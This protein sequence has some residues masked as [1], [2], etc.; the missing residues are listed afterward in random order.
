MAS[1]RGWP[2]LGRTVPG[3]LSQPPRRGAA[4]QLLPD[5]TVA[6]NIKR[7]RHTRRLPTS[8]AS[9]ALRTPT[10]S[11]KFG[12][13]TRR[14]GRAG[15]SRRTAPA[16]PS[17]ASRRS[18]GPLARRGDVQSRQRERIRS[19]G[20]RSLRRGR[21]VRHRASTRRYAAPIRFSCSGGG[22]SSAARRVPWRSK[23]HKQ[24]YDK[25]N[26][27]QYRFINPGEDFTPEPASTSAP[28]GAPT[29]RCNTQRGASPMGDGGD[30]RRRLVVRRRGRRGDQRFWALSG[31]SKNRA[32][33]EA[34]DAHGA[35]AATHRWTHHRRGARSRPPSLRRSR[36]RRWSGERHTGAGVSDLHTAACGGGGPDGRPARDF[37]AMIAGRWLNRVGFVAVATRL[38]LPEI[39]DRQRLDRPG[40]AVSLGPQAG[41]RVDCRRAHPSGAAI[42]TS[43]TG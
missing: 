36:R 37:E 6:E 32:R 11:S 16:S 35:V 41:R 28:R 18:D 5:G 22:S 2:R 39:R 26:F 20:L 24:L 29:T 14:P 17:R 34:H 4:G 43:P 19:D 42:P 27:E 33:P 25:H 40:R 31:R 9:A 13:A 7:W 23:G 1:S 3:R 38:V 10:S 30:T 8:S 21:T 12:R 15:V